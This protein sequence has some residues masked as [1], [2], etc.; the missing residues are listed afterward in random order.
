MPWSRNKE[1]WLIKVTKTGRVRKNW[2]N[3]FYKIARQRHLKEKCETCGGT[4][5]LTVDHYPPL[6]ETINTKVFTTM[7][8]PCHDILEDVRRLWEQPK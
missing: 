1:G 4:N 7:C 2:K 3:H 8:R 6:R 5:H